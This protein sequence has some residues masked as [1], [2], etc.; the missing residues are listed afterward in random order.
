MDVDE[1]VESVWHDYL[2][3]GTRG[4]SVSSQVKSTQV[5]FIY[6]AHLKTTRVSSQGE[7]IDNK[8]KQELKRLKTK[9]NKN[10]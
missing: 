5:T 10:I 1:E 6:L 7:S 9:K 4:A 2:E 8:N 3:T